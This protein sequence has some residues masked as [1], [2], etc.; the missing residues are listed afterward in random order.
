MYHVEREDYRVAEVEIGSITA[1]LPNTQG[2]IY[3]AITIRH[4]KN[5]SPS[6]FDVTFELGKIETFMTR[7]KLYFDQESNA[8]MGFTGITSYSS[9]KPIVQLGA[10]QFS[11]WES[12]EDTEK[13]LNDNLE[14]FYEEY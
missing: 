3:L 2:I 5:L 4:V 14:E 13:T 7:Q 12:I 10:I 11:C 9:S 6:P 8:F 1:G